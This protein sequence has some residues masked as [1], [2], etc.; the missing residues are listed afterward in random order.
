LGQEGVADLPG[1]KKPQVFTWGFSCGGD[2]TNVEP[3]HRRFKKFSSVAEAVKCRRNT[4]PFFIAFFLI[5][6]VGRCAPL[7]AALVPFALSTAVC[8]SLGLMASNTPSRSNRPIVLAEFIPCL[9]L[10]NYLCAQ[11]PFLTPLPPS[12][13]YLFFPV[14]FNFLCIFPMLYLF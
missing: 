13:L 7:A 8:V 5:W 6:D 1:V 2:R 10:P 3:A 9:Y 12:Q 4:R 14:F 11:H